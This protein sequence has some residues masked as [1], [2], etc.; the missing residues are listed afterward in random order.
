MDLELDDNQRSIADLTLQILR[1]S[2]TREPRIRVVGT[3]RGAQQF[4]KGRGIESGE[5]RLAG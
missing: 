4:L 1:E 5:A 2:L 3:A